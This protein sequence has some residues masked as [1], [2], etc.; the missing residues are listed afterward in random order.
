MMIR[1]AFRTLLAVSL[2]AMFALTGCIK[3][4]TAVEGPEGSLAVAGFFQPQAR[5]ELLAGYVPED[6]ELVKPKVLSDLDNIVAA[7]LGRNKELNWAGPHSV[8]QCQEMVMADEKGQVPAFAYWLEV[9]KCMSVDYLLVPQLTYWRDRE[10]GEHGVTQPA[11]VALDLFL[12]DVD[13]ES[14]HRKHF[15]EAQVSLS[16]NLLSAGKFVRRGGKWLT[17]QEL[18][19]EG[20]QDNL[21]ELGL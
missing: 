21:K 15:E 18:A 9:A 20:I 8:S 2:V 12:I 6:A 5:G 3:R 10:G 1:T 13:N 14:L 11:S 4:T 16:E 17:A 19:A 7:H